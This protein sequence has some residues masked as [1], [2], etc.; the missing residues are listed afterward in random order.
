MPVVIKPKKIAIMLKY[1][2]ASPKDAIEPGASR[3]LT[4]RPSTRAVIIMENSIR[5]ATIKLSVKILFA[6]YQRLLPDLFSIH[7]L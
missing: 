5:E 4:T 7:I 2:L 1:G 3:R 6:T